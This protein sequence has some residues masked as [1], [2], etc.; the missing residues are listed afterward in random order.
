MELKA[1]FVQMADQ[2][3]ANMSRPTG[4]KWLRR[5][6]D[7]GFKGLSERSRRP[8][9]SPNKTPEEIAQLVV[10]ARRRDPGWG[11]RK[12]RCHLRNQAAG[13]AIS[14]RPD[15]VPSA[16]TKSWIATGC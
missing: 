8:N 12:L 15:Q 10:E 11:G 6:R 14:I 13:G 3:N 16:S 5:Y 7:E 1:E 4:Y 9:N 2:S